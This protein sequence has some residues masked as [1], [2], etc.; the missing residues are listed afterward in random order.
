VARRLSVRGVMWGT[1]AMTVALVFGF[2]GPTHP[3]RA[4]VVPPP[5]AVSARLA[6]VR[7]D[8]EAP[9]QIEISLVRSQGISSEQAVV[10]A[11][12]IWRGRTAGVLLGRWTDS[13][14]TVSAP[15]QS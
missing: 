8:F 9:S 1:K 15:V 6:A 2:L 4:D 14:I 11:K 10:A 12:T 3:F 7:F 13:R 5:A